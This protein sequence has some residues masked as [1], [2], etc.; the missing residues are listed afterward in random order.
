MHVYS[1]DELIG[2]FKDGIV[3]WVL[4]L[5]ALRNLVTVP[6][7]PPSWWFRWWGY[8]DWYYGSDNDY[9]PYPELAT[10]FMLGVWR[11]LGEWI[12]ESA[13]RF[14]SDALALARAIIGTLP[15][16]AGTVARGLNALL[17]R[18]GEGVLF[19]ADNAIQASQKLYDWLPNEVKLAGMSWSTL[20]EF[21]KSSVKDWVITAYTETVARASNAWSWVVNSGATLGEWY[22]SVSG[23]VNDLRWNFTTRVT[24]SLGSAWDWLASFRAS[25][26]A[27]ID[28]L[29]GSG[30]ASAIRLAVDAGP[31][32]YNLWSSYH[33]ELG[34]FL[35]DPGAWVR[36]RLEAELN[37]IW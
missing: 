27:V 24:S 31:W 13:T 22:A 18:I 16:W 28:A 6:S 23:W 2:W 11:L 12:D 5:T 20:F 9:H 30:L 34:S 4:S 19:W 32:L 33:A 35:A 37:R 3:W 25:P 15:G 17:S 14:A 26:K 10:R 36:A 21:V 29:Y 1:I 7:Q 8:W